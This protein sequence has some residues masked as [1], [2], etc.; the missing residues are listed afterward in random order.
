MTE[1]EIG[2]GKRGRAGLR[3]RRHRD[4]AEPAHPRPR[5]GLDRLADRRLPLRAAAARRA[6]GLGGLARR[7]RSRS[8][9]SAAL[10][11]LNLEGL[12]TRYDDPEPLLR[13][14]RRRST[15]DGATARMQ[16]IYAAPIQP[17]LIAERIARGPRRRRHRR[18]RRCRRSARSSSAKTVVDAGVDLF[19]IRGTTVSAEHVSG[20]GRAAQP[21][22]VHLR[23]RRAGR[24]S[25]AC[26]TYTGG[27]APHAHRC[28]RRA[29]RLRRRRGAHHARRAS[30]SACRWPPRSPTSPRRGATTWT[31]PAAATC[32]S[33]PT[34]ASA[35]AATSPRR[36]PAAPTP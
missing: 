15:A 8:A 25:A 31:S 24:S 16:E 30:A 10:G 4:R 27:A 3:L 2:R 14:D 29:R 19:V 26:A 5:G 11:V 33:S 35:A 36:S 20:A 1:I 23:A 32:T 18:R 13:R 7:P 21:Q 34:A 22:A 12:W 9:G 17:D 28:G 6:D